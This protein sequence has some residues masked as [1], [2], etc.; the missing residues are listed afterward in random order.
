[1][2]MIYESKCN[3]CNKEYEYYALVKDYNTAMPMCC[4]VQTTKQIFSPPIGYMQGDLA[5]RCPVS[6][7]IVTNQ[8]Q[9][10]NIEAQHEITVIEKGMFKD[11]PKEKAPELPKDLQPHLQP[12]LRE[13]AS[14]V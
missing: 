6:D 5:Y 9:R 11:R 10:K 13:L 7:Q 8:R 2:P 3:K 14:Q 1:M 4:G 12:A